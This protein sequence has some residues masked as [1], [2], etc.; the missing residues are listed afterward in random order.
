MKLIKN[1]IYRL[2]KKY[3]D[4]PVIATL[5]S[6][7]YVRIFNRLNSLNYASET[8]SYEINPSLPKIAFVC[9]EMTWQDFKGECNS[10]F[11]DFRPDLF[12]CE[13]AWSGINKYR[14]CWRG[15]IYKSRNI[16]Y[17]NRHELMMILDY[18]RKNNIPAVFWN[19]E[20]PAFWGNTSYDFVDTALHFD[21]IFTTSQECLNKYIELGHKS[22]HVLMFGFSPSIFFFDSSIE[23]EKKA[24]FAGSW[25]TDQ[26]KRCADMEEIFNM[27]LQ[28]GI[29]LEIYDRQSESSNP[30]HRFPEKYRKFIHP[31][32]PYTELG[33]IYQKAEYAININTVTD[34]ETMFARRVFEIMACGCIVISNG[35]IGLKKLFADRIWFANEPFDINQKTEI[36]GKN[37]EEVFNYHTCEQRLKQVINTCSIKRNEEI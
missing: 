31:N 34:S 5:S 7:L 13:S 10:V 25:Y 12:F 14:N 3:Q 8:S 28:Y 11:D 4:N 15:R 24:V 35:S 20:D 33:K 21:H 36:R 2:Y 30:V 19:K 6:Y 17:E 23:K 37:M 1:R 16:R 18:C 32:V 9:D 29:P 26:P 22:V 27:V